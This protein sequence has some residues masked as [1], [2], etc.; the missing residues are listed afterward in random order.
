MSLFITCNQICFSF[1]FGAKLCENENNKIK[2]GLQLLQRFFFNY[3]LN[4]KKA[5]VLDWVCQI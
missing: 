4:H 3:F 1:F 5:R 2:L